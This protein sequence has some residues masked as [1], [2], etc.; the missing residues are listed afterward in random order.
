MTAPQKPS[1]SFFV[2]GPDGTVRLRLRLS[3]ERAS[4]I[5]EA[6][7]TTPLMQWIFSALDAQAHE[8]VKRRRQSGPVIPPPLDRD[9]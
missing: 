6:A 9:V 7:G 1:S 3:E 2:R 4:L 5:E 8:E